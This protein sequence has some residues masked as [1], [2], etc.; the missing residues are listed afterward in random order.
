MHTVYR[1]LIGRVLKVL[2]L[3]A[4]VSYVGVN[5]VAPLP[6]FLVGENLVYALLY[7]IAL[8]GLV[9]G[10]SGSPILL[11]GLSGFNAGRVSRSIITPTGEL[12]S[13]ALDHIPLLILLILILLLSSYM[14]YEGVRGA[15]WRQL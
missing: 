4:I 7:G 14:V 9:R 12:S 3:L 8:V 2:T 15:G 6:R 11:V 10:W 13:M 1:G 5:F